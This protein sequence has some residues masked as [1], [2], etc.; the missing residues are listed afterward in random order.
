[1]FQWQWGLMGGDSLLALLLEEAYDR[2]DRGS[3]SPRVAEAQSGAR[4]GTSATAVMAIVSKKVFDTEHKRAKLGDVLA[5]SRYAG[6]HK[7]LEPLSAGG[8]LYLVTARPGD[9]LWLVGVMRQPQKQDNAWVAEPNTVPITDISSLRGTIRFTSGKGISQ[10]KGALS[11]SLQ[12]PRE[13][14]AE[15]IVQ[16]TEALG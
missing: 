1:M 7:G 12:T 15:D 6:T 8:D 16:L 4:A 10:K 2:R 14:S 11:R 5:I 9:V 3:P 13:L